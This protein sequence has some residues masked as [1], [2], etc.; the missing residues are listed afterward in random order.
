MIELLA[1][2]KLGT[3]QP[4][5][6]SFLIKF[7]IT[8]LSNH[9]VVNIKEK[10]GNKKLCFENGCYYY[11]DIEYDDISEAMIGVIV[12][13]P[14][15]KWPDSKYEQEKIIENYVTTFSIICKDIMN[16]N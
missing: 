11:L 7:A 5:T 12:Y 14:D 10:L 6:T 16:T 13:L 4:G 9:D 2:E 3:L 1:K 15:S 8:D